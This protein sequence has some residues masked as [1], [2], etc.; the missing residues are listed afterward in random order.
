MPGR[1]KSQLDGL[2]S[3]GGLTNILTTQD[4]PNGT[5]HCI[6]SLAPGWSWLDVKSAPTSTA[7]K[8]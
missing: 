1:Q 6:V 2:P 3:I 8:R 5:V 7:S 4:A